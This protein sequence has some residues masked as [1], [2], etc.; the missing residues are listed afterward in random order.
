MPFRRTKLPLYTG[1][2]CIT[3]AAQDE[4]PCI[5]CKCRQF[6]ERSTERG[7]KNQ[8]PALSFGFNDGE[9]CNCLVG[10]PE[11]AKKKKMRR[12]GTQ[13]PS[14]VRPAA[15]A[16]LIPYF[17]LRSYAA[18]RV[19]DTVPRT[20]IDDHSVSCRAV[21]CI[22]FK[23]EKNC[24]LS[25]SFPFV[26]ARVYTQT[27]KAQPPIHRAGGARV[28]VHVCMCVRDV[29]VPGAAYDACGC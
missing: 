6:L 10:C 3:H 23:E 26:S 18:C 24:L 17:S 15:H 25:L 9:S 2:A 28:F 12:Q 16:A 13:K 8:D 7:E 22:C 4:E 19:A 21:I 1:G 27:G 5:V 29:V 11:A 14:A 20:V